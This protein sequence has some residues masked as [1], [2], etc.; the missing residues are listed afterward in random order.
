MNLNIKTFLLSLC[1][2][3]CNSCVRDNFE[4]N[5]VDHT[6][7]VCMLANNDLYKNALSNINQMEWA[8]K[9]GYNGNLVVLINPKDSNKDTYLLKIEHDNNMEEIKSPIIE[10][11][12][13]MDMINSHNLN[14]LICNT[15]KRYPSKKYSIILWSHATGWL[16]PNALVRS[17]GESNNFQMDIHNLAQ[18]IPSHCFET[19]IFDACYMGSVEVAYELKDKA[20]YIIASPSEITTLGFPYSSIIPLLFNKNVLPAKI[21]ASYYDFYK[22]QVGINKSATIGVVKTSELVKL[23]NIT[24]TVISNASISQSF[25]DNLKNVQCYDRYANKITFDFKQVID[26]LCKNNTN[27]KSAFEKAMDNAVIY[28]AHTDSFMNEIEIKYCSGL[29]CYVPTENANYE[30]SNYYK[31]LNWYKDSGFNLL[32]GNEFNIHR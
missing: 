4:E 3:A 12:K 16:P 17:F 15:Q 18:A 24:K 7:I 10:V 32:C 19:L 20:N 14:T 30:I 22:Q 6:V 9:N 26:L 27:L 28:T 1:L 2:I 29:S 5:T 23:V 11:F 8:W 31:T 25:Y 21:G 13:D